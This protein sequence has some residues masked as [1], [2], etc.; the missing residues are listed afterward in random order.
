[1]LLVMVKL[2]PLAAAFFFATS[3][4]PSMTSYPSG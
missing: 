1:M 3:T 4:T 2:P